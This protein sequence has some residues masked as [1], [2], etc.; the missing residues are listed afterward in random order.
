MVS[1]T[2]T[3]HESRYSETFRSNECEYLIPQRRKYCCKCNVLLTRFQNRKLPASPTSVKTPNKH[4]PFIHLTSTEKAKRDKRSSIKIRT[5]TRQNARHATRLKEMISEGGIGVDEELDGGLTEIMEE[6]GNSQEFEDLFKP[7]DPESQA[8]KEFFRIF[9]QQQLQAR[10]LKL[11]GKSSSMR[12][13]PLMVRFA[14]QMKMCSSSGL[15]CARNVVALPGD[16]MMFDYSHIYDVAEGCQMQFINE[17]GKEVE[18]MKKKHDYQIFHSLTFDEVT[19]CENLVQKKTTGEVV[20]YC[21]LNSVQTELLELRKQLEAEAQG[22]KA[23][24]TQ[25]PPSAKKMLTFM[26]RGTASSIQSV[27]PHTLSIISVKKIFINM[28]GKWLAI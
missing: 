21:K 2:N 23:L 15:S 8:D 19:I 12:W 7:D 10:K 17:I 11:Q 1:L 9:I 6:V 28:C 14:L 25:A 26:V 3:F 27:L 18:E 13:H 4:K 16:R 5:L 24:A 20:G 22:H